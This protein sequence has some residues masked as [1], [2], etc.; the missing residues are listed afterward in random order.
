MGE[1]EGGGLWK[2]EWA[3]GTGLAW[4]LTHVHQNFRFLSFIGL[5]GCVPF[6]SVAFLCLFTFSCCLV[7]C[8]YLKRRVWA[9][10]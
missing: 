3:K 6:A 2:G 5:L 4:D 7:V 8:P 9:R 10:E 1:G